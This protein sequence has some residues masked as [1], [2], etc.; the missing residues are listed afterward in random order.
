MGDGMN[1]RR[2]LA[3]AALGL[4]LSLSTCRGCSQPAAT[5]APVGGPPAPPPRLVVVIVV[6]QMRGDEFIDDD[7][8]WAGGMRR[9]RQEGQIWRQAMHGH[10]RTETA[11]GHASI[12][13]GVLPDV[14]GVVN[15]TMWSAQDR[16]LRDV[17]DWGPTPCE[18]LALQ[19]PTL[20]DRLKARWPGAR[21][22]S[23]AAK[24]RAASL[25]GGLHADLVAWHGR[26]AMALLGRQAG[27]PGV[28]NW[29]QAFFGQAAGRDTMARIWELPRLPAAFAQRPD[30]AEGELDCGHGLSFPHRL[31]DD[32]QGEALM[33][34]WSCTPDSDRVVA[35]TALVVAQRLQLGQDEAPDL[36]WLSF[37]ANDLVGHH[38]GIESLER[39]ATLTQLDRQ[40]GELMQGLQ[41]LVGPR[42]LV[43]LTADHGVAPKVVNARAAGHPSG[44]VDPAGL[45]A[46]VEAALA[47]RWGPGPHVAALDF[48][49]LSLTDAAG[50]ARPMAA[51][52][53]AEVLQQQ[54][55]VHGAW[56]VAD[57]PA[58]AAA[59]PSAAL[60]LRSVYPGRSGDVV[61]ALAPFFSPG[62]GSGALGGAAHGSPWPYDRHV[63]LVLWG[64]G[65]GPGASD[66]PVAVVDL[67][68][69]LADRLDLPV[70]PRGGRPLGP[71]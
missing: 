34:Q 55:H 11:A 53:A 23:L 50:A 52:R 12:A 60:L 66:A 18:P 25:M 8:L 3:L 68:R 62:A 22:V 40:L 27:V 69:T 16:A 30:R 32:V 17:C 38:Y 24:P 51:R 31:G 14:H 39:V 61:L 6:E 56:A 9:L 37:A 59:E 7:A 48:P 1:R 35:E 70:E 33:A 10:G 5:S 57:L 45:E 58:A 15:R 20:G 26:D 47:S 21:V 65:V 29:L 64:D 41:A 19:V 28:P 54:P 42:L 49:F 43:A 13:T 44:W 4:L 71:L 36:L 63:P 2:R 67:M 46:A